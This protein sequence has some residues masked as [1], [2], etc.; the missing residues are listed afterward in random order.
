MGLMLS[1]AIHVVYVELS[2]LR[3]IL[4]KPVGEMTDIEKWAVFF[5]YANKRRYRD[6]VNEVIQSKE[7][8]GMAGSLLMSVSQDEKERAVFQ[9]RKMYQTD[10]QSNWNTAYD[11]GEK[12]GR[13]KGKQEGLKEGKR[14]GLKEGMREGEKKGEKKG[15]R[16]VAINALEMNIPVGDVARM[17]GLSI[18]ELNKIESGDRGR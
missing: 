9:T 1:D 18:E 8:M 11:K 10:M 2:K 15:K 5:R 3:E 13:I 7:A 17:T 12:Q 16:E 14:E 4:K 6:T